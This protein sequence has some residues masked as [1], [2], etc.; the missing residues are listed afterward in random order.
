MGNWPITNRKFLHERFGGNSAGPLVYF[1]RI[2]TL[3]ASVPAVAESILRDF[4]SAGVSQ[5]FK[6]N[7][8]TTFKQ[9]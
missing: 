9:T 3:T 1:A 5:L 4:G 6:T 8:T 2:D 7:K